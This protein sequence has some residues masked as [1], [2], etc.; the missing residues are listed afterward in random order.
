MLEAIDQKERIYLVIEYDEN[1][2]YYLYVY[3]ID[4][5][6]AIADHLCDNLEEAFIEAEKI[7][8]IT[9]DKFHNKLS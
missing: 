1:V 6:N 8:H 2:G 4:S 9:R 3:P 5:D 7:Y